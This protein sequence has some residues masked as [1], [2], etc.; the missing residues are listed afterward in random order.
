MTLKTNIIAI[1]TTPKG[2]N[3]G[4]GQIFTAQKNMI[5]AIIGIGYGDGYPWSISNTACVK[6]KQKFAPIVGRVSMDM[7]AIDIG[8]AGN[9]KIGDSVVVWGQDDQA[10][11]PL[12]FAASHANTIPYVLLCQITSR[13]HYQYV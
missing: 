10:E 11:L 3:I 8:D 6:V 12:E 9:V 4:Y 7:M 13:V 2:Q 1:K 5:I